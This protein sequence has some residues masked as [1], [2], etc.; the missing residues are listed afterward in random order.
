[1]SVWYACMNNYEDFPT[2]SYHSDLTA[3][4]GEVSMKL[5]GFKDTVLASLP[6]WPQ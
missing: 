5:L 4:T 2:S 1:M 3:D 6:K